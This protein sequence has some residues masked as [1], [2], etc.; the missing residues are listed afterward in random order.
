[1]LAQRSD[2]IGF[3]F[4]DQLYSVYRLQPARRTVLQILLLECFPE[5]LVLKRWQTRNFE[6]LLR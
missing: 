1:M 5:S 6:G 3:L 4:Q 2:E